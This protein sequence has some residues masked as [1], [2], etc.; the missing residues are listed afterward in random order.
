MTDEPTYTILS[1][2]TGG[3]RSTPTVQSMTL[4]EAKLKYK[5][6]SARY[7]HQDFDILGVMFAG[8]R[9]E[10]ASLKAIS[11]PMPKPKKMRAH[12]QPNLKVVKA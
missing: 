2:T 7:P 5:E 1:R 10:R 8:N 12:E 9:I 3:W 4:E 11:Q 6:L